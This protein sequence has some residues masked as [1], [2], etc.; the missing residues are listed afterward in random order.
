M[1][2]FIKFVIIISII[3]SVISFTPG[4]SFAQ[5]GGLVPCGK[6]K[7]P[8]VTNPD[9]SESGGEI[10]D[11]CGFYDFLKLIDNVVDFMLFTLAVPIAAIMFAFAGFLMLFSGGDSGK[12]TRAKNIFLN[13]ALGLIFAAAAW[14]I[15]STLLS[16]AG[17]NTGNGWNWFGF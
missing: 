15:I 8:L 13:V 9:G 7:S 16:I 1:K 4:I 3:T 5:E 2:K 6:E 10:L 11:Q 12:R 14:L 17:Y